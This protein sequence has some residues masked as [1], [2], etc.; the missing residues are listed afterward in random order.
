MPAQPYQS[1][2]AITSVVTGEPQQRGLFLFIAAENEDEITSAWH[3]TTIIVDCSRMCAVL[4]ESHQLYLSVIAP[5]C[6][7]NIPRVV[8]GVISIIISIQTETPS[9]SY[10]RL[11]KSIDHF[12]I[13]QLG[14]HTTLLYLRTSVIR[15]THSRIIC[16]KVYGDSQFMQTIR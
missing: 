13:A 11:T 8:Q 7:R 6:S 10:T 12:T 16:Y 2:K 3:T 14:L 9:A 5:I 15:A 1:M 4:Y